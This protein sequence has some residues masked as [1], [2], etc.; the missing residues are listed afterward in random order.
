MNISLCNQRERGLTLVELFVVLVVLTFFGLMLIPA[1]SRGHANS[2]RMR[3]VNNLK[4]IGLAT[5]VWE[6]DH[7]DKYPFSVSE[8]NGGVREFAFGTNLWRN[9][10]V[11]SNELST[12][13]VL[14]CPTDSR[15]AAT[16]FVFLNNSNISF[17]IGIDAEETD[18]QMILA[19]DRNLTNGT[20]FKSG[21]LEVTTN[22][23]VGW[24][25][26]MHN[27]VGNLTLSD[28][29]VQQVSQ[30]GLRTS[31]QNTSLFTNRLLMPILGP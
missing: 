20:P 30:T 17:F 11:M 22:T 6:G 26:L 13:K 9:F 23:P 25:A 27:H 16:N 18:P 12:P 24:T 1:R 3:C 21:I 5:R 4:Q 29:S 7:G 10:Q 31:V 8:T 15:L 28:G 19:G 2:G 14:I